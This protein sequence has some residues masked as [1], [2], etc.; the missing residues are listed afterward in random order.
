MATALLVV[1]GVNVVLFTAIAVS[2]VR[3]ALA[4]EQP[5]MRTLAFGLT[6]ISAAFVLGAVSR[7]VLVAQ[8]RADVT[9]STFLTSSWHLG[10]SVLATGLGVGGV[11]VL[12]QVGRPLRDAERLAG[13][14]AARLPSPDEFERYQLTPRELEVLGVLTDG[15]LTDR[16]IADALYIS[17]AT[18]GTHVKNIM[19][20][21][22]VS[23]RRDLV[24]LAA[25]NND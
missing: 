4:E 11:W 21:A 13:V 19:R 6:A 1:I 14:I 5:G 25:S 16:D 12:R 9:A 24:L 8:E 3:Y 22:D 7:F 10:Q 18:A 17:P 15:K 23:S 2:A 20:K